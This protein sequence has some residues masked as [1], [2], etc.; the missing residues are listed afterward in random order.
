MI[1]ASVAIIAVV[2]GGFGGGMVAVFL[3]LYLQR[4]AEEVVGEHDAPRH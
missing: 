3:E 1:G 2:S 4:R